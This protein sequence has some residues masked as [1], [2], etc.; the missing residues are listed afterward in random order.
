MIK[1]LRLI[2]FA[3]AA[4]IAFTTP[5][6]A[7]TFVESFDNGT[8]EQLSV[9]LA[10]GAR[11]CN[12][13][14]GLYG[15]SGPSLCLFNTTD[16]TVFDFPSDVYVQGFEFVA[17]AKN[18]TTELT[19]TY[20]D[21]TTGRFPIDGSCCETTV[22]VVAPE[23]QYV[24]S[25]SIPADPDLWLLD[26][27]TWWGGQVQTTTTTTEPSTTIPEP[28]TTLGTTTSSTSTISSVPTTAPA[29]A[30]PTPAVEQTTVPET[31]ILPSTSVAPSTTETPVTTLPPATSTIPSV[32]PSTTTLAPPT[33]ESTD[34]PLT[35]PAQDDSQGQV[36]QEP[37]IQEPPA[38]ASPEEKA[39]FESQVDVFSGAYDNYVPLGSKITVA[40]RR[41][42]VAVTAVLIMLA[43]PPSTMRRRQ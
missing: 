11:Y 13:Y 8:V 10:P 40:Q 34:T 17:G 21:G 14:S 6:N 30:S 37:L 33:T 41:T 15:T 4:A 20:D 18:G 3:P 24:V 39:A 35:A 9:S 28:S 26:T 1:L 29:Q 19:A 38:D 16:E 31:S 22:Q 12:E 7:E 25:F 43:P 2:V 42:V 36:S 27:L 5:S 23:G 32:P